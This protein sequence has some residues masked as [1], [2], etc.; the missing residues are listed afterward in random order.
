MKFKYTFFNYPL[1]HSF[2]AK[3]I[4]RGRREVSLDLGLSTEEV[5]REGEEIVLREFRVAVGDV[6][7]IAKDRRN[8]IWCV[9]EEGLLKLL[10]FD[11][12]VYK[13]RLISP[14]TAPT[15]EID[16][17]HMHR[18]KGITPWED[19]RI[20][21]EVLDVKDCKVLDICTGL[22]YTAIWEKKLGASEVLTVEK[23]ENVLMIAQ[24]NPWSRGLGEVQIE[25]GD[26]FHFLGNL[27]EKF[28]RILIDPPREVFAPELYSRAF[29]KKVLKVLDE[30]GKVF[31]YTGEPG[32]KRGRVFWRDVMRRMREVGFKKLEYIEES[33]GILSSIH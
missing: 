22:G 18:I 4:L 11:G 24:F 33:R 25:V 30:K 8:F 20:K 19:A 5:Q 21:V 27:R 32:V 13:L 7:K 14:H 26:A 3:E 6:E 15:L 1:L 23:D 9:R 29:F 10:F 12:R 2:N 17:V 31:I 16:G 28:D